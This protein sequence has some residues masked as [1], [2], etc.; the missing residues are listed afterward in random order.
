MNSRGTWYHRL[1]LNLA[2]HLKK[3][4]EAI[5]ACILGIKDP[6]LKE[7]DKLELQNRL[8]KMSKNWNTSDVQITPIVLIEPEKVI[9]GF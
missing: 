5:D 2:S 6:L 7:K 3:K 9:K 1:V 4:A 8:D